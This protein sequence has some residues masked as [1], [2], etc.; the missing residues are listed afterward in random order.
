[1]TKI[2]SWTIRTWNP[3]EKF[4]CIA[5]TC[6]FACRR[7]HK[8]RQLHFVYSL[9]ITHSPIR[10]WV[11][12]YTSYRHEGMWKIIYA[13][14]VW[15]ATTHKNDF[16]KRSPENNQSF[17]FYFIVCWAPYSRSLYEL[18]LDKNLRVRNFIARCWQ[19][20]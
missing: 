7:F 12:I 5:M 16:I 8:S 3:S 18:E 4:I 9:S 17:N 20:V 13:P 15:R 10:S 1:M 6:L 14:N 11:N 19:R 2:L